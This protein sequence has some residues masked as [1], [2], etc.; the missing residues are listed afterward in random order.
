MVVGGCK[1]SM[2]N[3]AP[4]AIICDVDFIK[5]APMHMLHAGLGDM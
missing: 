4:A 1:N 3:Q 2:T 5:D